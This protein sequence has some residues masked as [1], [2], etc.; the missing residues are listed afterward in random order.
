[1]NL[2]DFIVLAGG[3]YMV[4]AAFQLKNGGE[5]NSNFIWDKNTPFSSCKD[6][7]GFR[8][9]VFPRLLISGIVIA[10]DGVLGIAMTKFNLYEKAYPFL[11][12]LTVVIIV[13]YALFM[14][15]AQKLFF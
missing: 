3:A 2:I 12:I 6:K 9:Y 13:Y 14:K 7:D 5:I 11:M 15:K 8:A 1:M 4:Y 10:V